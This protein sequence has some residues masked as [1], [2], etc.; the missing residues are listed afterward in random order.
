M[1]AEALN[2]NVAFEW[3]TATSPVHLRLSTA[4]PHPLQN[5]LFGDKGYEWLCAS[6]SLLDNIKLVPREASA[7]RA[8]LEQVL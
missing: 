2:L 7:L 3:L 6:F 8:N 1:M 5:S 4:L